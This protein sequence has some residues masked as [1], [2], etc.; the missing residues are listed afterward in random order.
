MKLIYR[1]AVRLCLVL[2]P[3]MALW[4]WLFYAS[5]VDEIN[6]EVDDALEDYSELIVIRMMAGQELPGLNDGSN[7]NYSITPVDERYVASRPMIDYR[8]AEVYIPEK[9]ETEPARVLTTI[10]RDDAGQFYELRVSTPSFEK[11]DLLRTAAYWA[12]FLYLL[13]LLTVLGLTLLVFQR[14]LR[15]LYALL[16]WLDDY[17]PGTGNRPVPN[18]TTIAEFRRLNVAAQEALDRSEALHEQQKQFIGNASHELQTPLAVLGARLEWL[19]DGPDVNERQA[20]EIIQMQRTL[21]HIVRL[22]RTLL[23]LTKIDNNQFPENSDV[24]IAALVREQAELCGEIYASR[25]L[26]CSPALPGS[27][28]VRMNESLASVLVTNLVKNAYLHS[29]PGTRIDIRI[30]GR[31]LTVS[32]EGGGALDGK[33]IFERFYQGSKKEG[34]TGLGLALVRAVANYYALAIGYRFEN[35]RHLFSVTWP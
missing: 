9:K 10:F 2:L 16:R 7:N 23:L 31:T 5:M 24:D 25:G 14:N 11:D 3:I 4:V 26:V 32:N 22:N 6:D 21:S 12:V 1:L 34:S 28:T 13:L 35:G 15:P 33:R 29:E 27:F 19:L 18:D 20:G 30:E 8:D 17:H